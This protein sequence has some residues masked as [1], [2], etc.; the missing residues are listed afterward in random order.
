VGDIGNPD[1]GTSQAE[2]YG[3]GGETG[4]VFDA[5]DPLFLDGG[6]NAALSQKHGRSVAVI[7]VEA[8]DVCHLCHKRGA[9][10]RPRE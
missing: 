4:R 8:E 10:S 5:I 7:R 1:T 3:V 2:T 6:Y 9:I